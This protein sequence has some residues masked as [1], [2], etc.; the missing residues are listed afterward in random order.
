MSAQ[1]LLSLKSKVAIVT[2][3]GK[4]N[5]IGAAVAYA[6]AEQGAKVCRTELPKFSLSAIVSEISGIIYRFSFTTSLSPVPDRPLK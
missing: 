4:P 2:G 5:G 3:S 6:L 1:D